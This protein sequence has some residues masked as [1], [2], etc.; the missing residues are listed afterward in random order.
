MKKTFWELL[1]EFSA[2]RRPEGAGSRAGG[3]HETTILSE[4]AEK[5]DAGMEGVYLNRELSWLAFNGRVLEEAEREDVPLCERLNF[6]AIYQRNLDEFFMVRVGSLVDQDMLSQSIRENKTH[7]TARAQIR[8][9]LAQVRALDQR[10]T[11]VYQT[12]MECLGNEGVGLVDFRRLEREK[13]EALETYFDTE[14][15]VLLSPIIV[16]KRHR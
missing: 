11:A 13:R 8:A 7:M 16:G 2:L 14:I 1:R 12:L 4:A 3:F 15:A 5:G 10:K 9:V 6:L